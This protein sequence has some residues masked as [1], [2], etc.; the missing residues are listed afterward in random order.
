MWLKKKSNEFT[1]PSRSNCRGLQTNQRQIKWRGHGASLP[2]LNWDYSAGQ[3]QPPAGATE[4]YAEPVPFQGLNGLVHLFCC[5]VTIK[6]CLLPS[7]CTIVGLKPPR[8]VRR[9]SVLFRELKILQLILWSLSQLPQFTWVHPCV[10]VSIYRE[11][12][13]YVHS[14]IS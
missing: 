14:A 1:S 6:P 3:G 8:L 13:N 4:G 12:R 2:P 9:P 5:A 10:W 7:C 11:R